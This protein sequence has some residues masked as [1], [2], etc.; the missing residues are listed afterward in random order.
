MAGST[1]TKTATHLDIARRYIG[2]HYDDTMYSR[3]QWY[4]YENGVWNAMHDLSISHEVWTLIE[5]FEMRGE[6]R[7]TIST[8]N[9]VLDRVKARLFIQEEQV[10]ALTSMVNLANGVFN[11]DD[12]G[13]LYSHKPEYYFTTQLPFG[14]DSSAQC[15]TWQMY[16]YSTFVKP[17][18]KVADPEL[19]EF[20]Q[21]A[22]GYSLTTDISHHVMFWCYGGGANGKGVLFHVIEQL[23]GN[24]AMPLNIGLL[25]REPYQLAEL[26]GKRIALCSEASSTDNLVDDAQV[27]ALVAGDTMPARGIYR[28]PFALHPTAKLWWAMNKLPAVADTSEGF[29]RRVRVIPFNRQ[30]SKQEQIRDLKDKL[31]L[32]L[33]GIFNWAMGG[34]RR[35]R[36][37][38]EF[39]DPQQVLKVTNQYRKES[40]PVA[41]FVEEECIKDENAHVQSS[42]IYAGYKNWCQLNTYK[43]LSAKRF[44]AEMERMELYHKPLAAHNVYVG[45]KL[46]KPPLKTAQGGLVW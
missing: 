17:Q 27:K 26:A 23:A 32:E 33:P 10:D 43:A 45:V 5:Q 44:K 11:M 22:I 20:M 16:L 21:E 9:T 15:P 8:K 39:F 46:K 30:F 36:Q 41:L 6:C 40:N 19:I 28:Q 29:W 35:L 2:K 12:G 13:N 24:S 34:L 25:R 3:G 38:R 18:T 42:V 31:D 14:Y 37:R 7:P 4:K 1:K